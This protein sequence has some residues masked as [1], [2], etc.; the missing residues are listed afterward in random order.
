MSARVH[1]GEV[2]LGA[3]AASLRL[4]VFATVAAVEVE[5]W[6]LHDTGLWHREDTEHIAHPAAL[7]R[8]LEH[9]APV[10]PLVVLVVQAWAMARRLRERALT[11]DADWSAIPS[12][13]LVVQ[14]DAGVPS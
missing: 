2:Q 8:Y 6:H 3:G 12:D 13:A 4:S 7:A 10:T 1:V 5:V 14:L 9:T 11:I